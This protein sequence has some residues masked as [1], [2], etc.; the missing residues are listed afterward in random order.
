MEGWSYE[1]VLAFAQSSSVVYFTVM[2][3]VVLVYALWPSNK[4]R[5][6]EAARIPLADGEG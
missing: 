3:A 5:F 1:D 2:F 4:A 6:D